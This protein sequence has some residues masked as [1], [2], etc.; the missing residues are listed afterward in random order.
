MLSNPSQVILRNA[1]LFLNHKVLLLNYESDLLGKELLTQA[2]AVDAL[3]LDY[4]HHLQLAPHGGARLNTF[5]GHDLDDAAV[6]D[7]VILFFPKAK[8]LAPYLFNL[9][10]RH[11][12]LGGQLLVVG[13]NKGGIKSL[14]K[15]LPDYFSRGIKLDNARHCLLFSSELAGEA[16]I[17]PLQHWVN[18]YQLD[19]PQGRLTI[20][21]LVGVF[22]DKHL[23]QG[24]ELL[25][26]HLPMLRGR[27]LDFGCGA[28][29]IAAALL[30][31]QPELQLECVDINAMALASCELTM[32]ANGLQ[33]KIY[34][35]DGLQQTVG[36]FDA[37]VS[38]PPFHDG[39]SSTTEIAHKFVAD[40]AKNLQPGGQWHIVANRHL[41]YA[42]T[43]AHHFGGFD[44]IAENNKFKVYAGKKR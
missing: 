34:P 37:I 13:E 10:G 16:P 7:T 1:E 22:S 4:H 26:T 39:L 31:A 3:A 38:N 43:I 8:A 12:A 25:L 35:S 11:L 42:D 32:H 33:A 20:C 19:T 29:V 23:D 44:I 36:S 6:Y 2:A 28:G 9:A 24:T 5:F 21:N 18:Q 27:V 30:K 17:L 40:S 41:P 14:P 15:L